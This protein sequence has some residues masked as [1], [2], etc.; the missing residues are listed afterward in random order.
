MRVDSSGSLGLDSDN[1]FDLI[2]ETRY[3][4][5]SEQREVGEAERVSQRLERSKE[6]KIR[7]Q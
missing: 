3:L 6:A 4:C 2:S 7:K 5:Y 1:I